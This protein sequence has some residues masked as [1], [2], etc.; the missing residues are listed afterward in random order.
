MARRVA[1][2]YVLLA[3]IILA[4]IAS[5]SF[6]STVNATAGAAPPGFTQREIS[7]IVHTAK[8]YGDIIDSIQSLGGTVTVR[9]ENA[10]AIAAR[11]PV[12]KIRRL[13]ADDADHFGKAIPDD[14]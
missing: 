8:P 7:L 2:I 5:S 1:T 6:H 3:S 9:Y 12:T 11:I 10:D 14:G 13:L 4:I